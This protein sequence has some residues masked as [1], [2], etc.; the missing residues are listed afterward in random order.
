VTT[1]NKA[2]TNWP[3]K[4]SVHRLQQTMEPRRVG[5]MREII[6]GADKLLLQRM[7]LVF[8]DLPT[9]YFRLKDA[10]DTGS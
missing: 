2:F 8:Q 10:A 7:T 3:N 9:G 4:R 5:D 1:P 6:G